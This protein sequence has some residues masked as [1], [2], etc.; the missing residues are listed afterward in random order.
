MHGRE[1]EGG[2]PRRRG[3]HMLSVPPPSVVEVDS[4]SKDGRKISVGDCA[5]FQ[6][7][8]SPPFIGLIRWFTT[9]EEN[10]LK[11]GVNWLYRPADVKLG[12]G[13]LLEAAPNE[14]FYSF[15][16][17]EIPAASLLHPCKVA[18]LP[19]GIE[20][21]SGIS[22]FVCRRVYDIAN[23]CL[24]WLTDQDYINE[25]QEEVDQLLNK[26]R[27]EM[28]AAVQ[29]GGRSPK[30]LNGSTPTQQVKSG[31]DSVQNSSSSYTQQGKG[32]KR[33]RSDQG[34]EPVKRE[35][36][37][38]Q[39][40][41][42]S[43]QHRLE[44]MI[45]GEIGKITDKEGG[46]VN[47]EAVDKLVHLMQLDAAEK[48]NDLSG[49]VLLADVIAAT[50]RI[51]CLDRFVQL[52][53][54]RVL[55]DW[56]QEAHKGKTGDGSSPKESDKCVEE[57]LLTLLR[58]LDK[59]PVNLQA[60]QTCNIGKSVNNLRSHKNSE[61]QKKSRSL[62]DIWK[63]RV[64]AEM[65]INDAKSGSAQTV[66]W[67]NKPG[68]SEIHAGSNK[69]AGSADIA[70]KSSITQPSACKSLPVKLIHG[71]A[72]AKPLSSPNGSLK[73]PSPLSASSAINLKDSQSK[74]AGNSGT[75]EL[76]LTPIKEEK[77]SSSSQSQNN[78]Q[79]FS[80]EHVK[81][82]GSAW[83]EDV[84][85]STAGSMNNNANKTSGG[86]SR[87]RRSS[88]G[89]PGS[90]V[91]GSQKETVSTKS[92]TLGRSAI[93]SDKTSHSGLTCERA[94]DIPLGDHANS[95]RLIVRL[96]NPGRSPAR[97]GNSGGS[98]EDPSVVGSRA[99]SPGPHEKH[100][101]IDRKTK[102]RGEACRANVAAD[103]NAESWQSN[104]VK[105]GIA[106]PDE[107]DRASAAVLDEEGIQNAEEIGK[108]DGLRAACSSSGSGKGVLTESKSGKPYN[109]SLSSMHALIESCA[110]HYEPSASISVGDDTGMNLLASVAAGEMSNSDMASPVGS[111]GRNS[112]T[113][114]EP[115]T[116]NKVKLRSPDDS[117]LQSYGQT[118]ECADGH[119]EKPVENLRHSQVKD[120]VQHLEQAMMTGDS[121]DVTMSLEHKH[122]N[123][124]NGQLPAS[125]TE[126]VKAEGPCLKPDRKPDEVT[127][128]G[129]SADMLLNGLPLKDT[130]EKGHEG[131]RANQPH[132]KWKGSANEQNSDILIDVKTKIKSSSSEEN[133]MDDC[134]HEKNVEVGGCDVGN[135]ASVKKHEK[136]GGEE[137]PSC[138][139][140]DGESKK[141][142]IIDEGCGDAF[143]TSQ[144]MQPVAVNHAD[145]ADNKAEC[146]V[147]FSSSALILHSE[148]V[149]ESSA[150]KG[151][152][153]GAVNCSNPS[154]NECKERKS[155]AHSASDDC[156][157]HGKKD[158]V[159]EKLE[160]EATKESRPSTL[161]CHEE[162][163]SVSNPVTEQRVKRPGLMV[164]G[165]EVDERDESASTAEA[166][167]LSG[168]RHDF[169]LNE[170]F[171]VDD[172]HQADAVTSA[173]P[174]GS[175]STTH[176]PSLSPF[177]ITSK[178]SAS[179]APITIAAP[180][181]GPFVPFE[182]LLRSKGEPGWRGSA[183]TSAFRPAEPRKVL[184]MPLST[185]DIHPLSDA[186]GIGKQSRFPL[187]IDLNVA[188]EIVS[189]DVVSQTSTQETGR[190]VNNLNCSGQISLSGHYPV[191]P[192]RGGGLD[193]D[194]NR[195]DEG[196]ENTQLPASSSRRVEVPLLPV[197]PSSSGFP[198]GEANILR[199]FD[200]NNGP[201]LDEVGS[202]PAFQR[203]QLVKTNLPFLPPVA[204]G[205]RMSNAELGSLSSWL[206]PGTSY[207]TGG[208][209][210]F[211][212]ERGDQQPYSMRIMG[213]PPPVATYSS[214]LYRG[215][216]LSSSPAMSFSPAAAFPYGNFPFGSSTSFSS[217]PTMYN[218]DTSSGGG[219]CFPAIPQIV[220]PGSAVSTHYPRP[221]VMSLSEGTASGG[222]EG[223]RK[224]GRQVLDLNAGPGS[225][226]VEGRDD[227]L[228]TVPRQQL[229]VAGSQAFVEEQGR[230]YQVAA[231]AGSKRKE[232]EGGWDAE[233]FTYKQP[234]WQ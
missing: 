55:D 147:T 127:K 148:N 104:E 36:S 38:K 233:R 107:G 199:D 189:E 191:A 52:K 57:F 71:D 180:A 141:I 207:S 156:V 46:L 45:K 96:P 47:A 12:K 72:V 138:L 161:T 159:D 153:T 8:N 95:H 216:V 9:D 6:A 26:T 53:G 146:A 133:K 101:H 64:D 25:R 88:N 66:T 87:H 226:D 140:I 51:D 125:G 91:S 129:V 84:R 163:S 82:T 166:S 22:S 221:H 14:V 136:E 174:G 149:K 35:R 67:P 196:M 59:L 209:P 139:A 29:S 120:E 212:P 169:D 97:C 173:A 19:K 80:S 119:P 167:S 34:L 143:S 90:V 79:S 1:G 162:P 223:I 63:K 70:T 65:K 175:S 190:A 130:R 50:D 60:L 137:P 157:T 213:P 93:A 224:W 202:D 183:A 112:P 192:V 18:F 184:E 201:V 151:D 16:K 231:G 2:T 126:T 218:M 49:R 73:V 33:D 23:K 11:L 171:P 89:F 30:P 122:T 158:G 44:T 58:A 4:F 193:L 124:Q 75:S 177:S 186:S 203:N 188:D 128:D 62:V 228:P 69:R 178:P 134:M 135:P 194:L 41:G 28:H 215:S 211:F 39:E 208:I 68:F 92:T 31:S 78:S 85:S 102:V 40:D 205:L 230:I 195:V 179:P 168:A 170:G 86:T 164:S 37:V 123:N 17:D 229:S 5:L 81:N 154:G 155:L 144:K 56:L 74:V 43:G 206:P 109:S 113:N 160:N 225:M 131:D 100:D 222:S 10:Y 106:Y 21:P 76:P 187:D 145:D 42:D 182:N 111:F 220:G 3:R 20:L 13:I 77:S 132:D 181:K 108:M 103:A 214:D 105:E 114:K 15:H 48:K 61:I 204:A 117:D 110:V 217:G 7:G 210:S 219:V 185:S 24:W 27:L 121:K 32:K 172:G 115:F 232:P 54:V 118:D 152:K 200:L 83:K 142:H 116:S 197:R 234:T 98:F 198:N 165:A 99:S 94:V 176:L 150:E 227:R